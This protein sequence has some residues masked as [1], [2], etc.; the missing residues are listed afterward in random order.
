MEDGEFVD[1]SQDFFPHQQ[2]HVFIGFREEDKEFVAAEAAGDVFFTFGCLKYHPNLPQ[3]LISCQVA[4]GVIDLFEM[5][6]VEKNQCDVVGMAFG[7]GYFLIEAILKGGAAHQAGEKVT[8]GRVEC[9]FQDG[10]LDESRVVESGV[11]IAEVV[12]GSGGQ[13]NLSLQVILHCSGMDDDGIPLLA[14]ILQGKGQLDK[15]VQKDLAGL[16]L[17]GSQEGF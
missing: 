1:L 11:N 8:M 2:S 16:I 7:P 10:G 5:V 9:G 6:E 17:L 14:G 12:T 13:A 3:G 15:I 4:M